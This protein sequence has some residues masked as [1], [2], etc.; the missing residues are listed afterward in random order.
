MVVRVSIVTQTWNSQGQGS[1]WHILGGLRN[2]RHVSQ[3][4]YNQCKGQSIKFAQRN[5]K[6]QTFQNKSHCDSG[7]TFG[8][9]HTQM[10]MHCIKGEINTFF[11]SSSVGLWANSYLVKAF[12]IWSVVF[13]SRNALTLKEQ[14]LLRWKWWM[15]YYQVEISVNKMKSILQI[16]PKQIV[17]FFHY[18]CP[19]V[20]MYVHHRRNI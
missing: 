15:R 19:S 3:D 6:Q 8:P 12:I 1:A 5:L 10:S 17:L 9:S 13:G 2:G 16:L 4:L 18:V 14:S 11:I 20:C 7:D